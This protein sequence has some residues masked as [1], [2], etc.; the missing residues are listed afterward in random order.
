MRAFFEGLA[1][2]S[3]GT[4]IVW[5]VSLLVFLVFVVILAVRIS[6]SIKNAAKNNGRINQ[7][8]AAVPADKIGTINAVYQNTRKSTG[9]GLLLCIVG[10]TFGFQRIYLGKEKSALAMFLFFWTGIPTIISLF[11]L[12][13]MPETVSDY[14]LNVVQSLYSQIASPISEKP[15]A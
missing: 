11:D 8:L 10:G 3:K 6:N 2:P 13:G 4:L 9:H 7:Y 1:L 5:G 12:A 15:Q 14:N